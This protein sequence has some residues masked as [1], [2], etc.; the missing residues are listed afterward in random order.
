MVQVSATLVLV[1]SR[2][3]R[4]NGKSLL[5]PFSCLC[6]NIITFSKPTFVG[7]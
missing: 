2:E 3:I 6:A 7:G 5:G 1:Y 4:Q